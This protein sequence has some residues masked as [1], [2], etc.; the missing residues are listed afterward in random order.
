MARDWLGW[1]VI[2]LVV[3]VAVG[4]AWGISRQTIN[5]DIGY[6][7]AMADMTVLVKGEICR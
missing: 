7:E 5:Y 4:Y 2:T 6:G 3:G 1:M